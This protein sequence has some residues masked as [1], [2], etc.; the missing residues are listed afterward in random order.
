MLDISHVKLEKFKQSNHAQFQL[1]GK[2][3]QDFTGEKTFPIALFLKFPLWKIEQ[4]FFIAEKKGIKSSK[5]IW[6][7]CKN[8]K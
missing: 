3:I 7:I 6:G 2:C 8:I 4:A 5:Y 1:I